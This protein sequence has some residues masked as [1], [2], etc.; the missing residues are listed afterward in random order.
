MKRHKMIIKLGSTF[1]IVLLSLLVFQS[2]S[3][4]QVTSGKLGKLGETAAA[5]LNL[6][7]IIPFALR[8]KPVVEVKNLLKQVHKCIFNVL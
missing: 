5:I 2:N 3:S 7:R 8:L 6:E 4:A 1:A